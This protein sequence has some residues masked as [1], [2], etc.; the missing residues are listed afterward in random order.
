MA[1]GFLCYDIFLKNIDLWDDENNQVPTSLY[2][3][4]FKMEYFVKY[5][6]NYGKREKDKVSIVTCIFFAKSSTLKMTTYFKPQDIERNQKSLQG[7]NVATILNM[8]VELVQ[9]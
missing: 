5:H 8:H 9:K 6:D 1:D 4:F 2:F 7:I 3:N